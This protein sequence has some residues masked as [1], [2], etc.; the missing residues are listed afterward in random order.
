M[1]EAATVCR[2]R[3][4]GVSSYNLIWSYPQSLWLWVF[5]VW[6]PKALQS[7]RSLMPNSACHQLW[8]KHLLEKGQNSNG[9]AGKM[10]SVLLRCRFRKIAASPL[11]EDFKLNLLYCSSPLKNTD[12]RKNWPYDEKKIFRY[13]HSCNRTAFFAVQSVLFPCGKTRFGCFSYLPAAIYELLILGRDFDLR[14]SYP[15]CWMWIW[16]KSPT[17]RSRIIWE[18]KNKYYV[19]CFYEKIPYFKSF[20]PPPPSWQTRHI[21]S[22]MCLS[23]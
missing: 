19:R 5:S 21:L 13:S 17:M 8:G 9:S 11:N 2:D 20:R 12:R 16:M 6:T 1:D 15:R 14:C 18:R 3:Q 10:N 23:T 4:D 22:V 7:S